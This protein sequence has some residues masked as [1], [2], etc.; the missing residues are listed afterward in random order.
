MASKRIIQIRDG[1]A[2]KKARSIEEAL[3][4][5]GEYLRKT[6]RGLDVE[7]R[8]VPISRKGKAKLTFV[9]SIEELIMGVDSKEEVT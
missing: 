4:D 2:V 9:D 7:I 1:L 8:L 5:V 3:D 6:A